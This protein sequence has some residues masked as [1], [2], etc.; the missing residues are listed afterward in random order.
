MFCVKYMYCYYYE[1]ELVK[2]PVLVF[3]CIRNIVK[4]PILVFWCIRNIVKHPI[5]VSWCIRNIVKHPILVSWCICN[6]FMLQPVKRTATDG[7][8]ILPTE[9]NKVCLTIFYASSKFS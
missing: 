5:L 8:I 3:W 9:R 6:T 1:T 4:H 7:N 2:R